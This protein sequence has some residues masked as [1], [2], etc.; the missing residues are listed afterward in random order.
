MVEFVG[1]IELAVGAE[2]EVAWVVERG[3]CR[4]AVVAGKTGGAIAGDCFDK[5]V[6]EVNT[7]DAIIE[8]IGDV[9]SALY[10]KGQAAGG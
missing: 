5:I 6:F 10:V 2:G 4:R 1:D 9:E 7:A 3:A 8:C